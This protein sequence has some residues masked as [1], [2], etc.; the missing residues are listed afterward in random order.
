MDTDTLPKEDNMDNYFFRASAVD[1]KKIPGSPI[2]YWVSEKVRDI[3]NFSDIFE[4]FSTPRQGLGTT[5]NELFVK[6]WFEVNRQKIAFNCSDKIDA[7]NSKCKWF[8]YSKGGGYRKWFGNDIDVVNW[9]QDGIDIKEALIGKNPNIPRSE[10]Q[11]FKEGITWGLI[12]SASFSARFSPQG[13]IFDVG[14]SKAFPPSDSKEYFLGLLNSKLSALFL[15]TLN[16]TLNF[17]VGDLKKIPVKEVQK[18]KF[19]FEP[20]VKKLVAFEKLDWDSYENSW[21]FSLL[22]LLKPQFQSSSLETTYQQLREHWQQTT[23][24]MRSLEEENNRI[25]IEAYGLQDELKPDVPIEEI[26]LTCNPAYRYGGERSSDELEEQLKADT[27]REF[28]SY[29]V[30]C[31]LGRY[32]LDQPGLILAN[33]GEGLE[34]YLQRIPEPTFAPD[35]DNVIP[36]L[37]GDWFTDDIVERF[38]RFLKLTFGEEQFAANRAYIEAALGKKGKPQSL[39]DYFLKDFY[40][41]HLKRY[42]KRPIYWL[43]SSPKGSFNALIYMHRYRPD[44]VSVILNDYLRDFIE[45]VKAQWE[46]E[47][48]VQTS[49]NASKADKSRALKE[50]EKLKKIYQELKE[51]EREILYPLATQKIEIDLDDGVKVNYLRFGTALKKIPGL[52]AKED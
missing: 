8:P 46:H 43:F 9:L 31:M 40:A 20:I 33:Q 7:L 29:A 10:S 51:Y 12:T 11:Y 30:G 26:T 34:D 1:F 18:Y 13:G 52:E 36:I 24:E 5:N 50:A 15:K 44:T 19:I 6:Y 23:Q 42:K 45:K 48:R 16:P 28:I 35:A 32:S 25:F 21:D 37:D 49:E 27:M 47:E 4:S 22:P 3:F 39:R 17:Q 14:G 38:D 2:A 41:D